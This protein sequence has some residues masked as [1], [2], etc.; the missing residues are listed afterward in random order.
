MNWK[1]RKAKSRVAAL[2]KKAGRSILGRCVS[3]G[4]SATST[5]DKGIQALSTLLARL[6]T[7]GSTKSKVDRR[8]NPL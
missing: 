3:P 6:V 2:R 1:K 8:G 5:I 7:P 4:P